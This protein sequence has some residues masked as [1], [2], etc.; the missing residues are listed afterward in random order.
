MGDYRIP[1]LNLPVAPKTTEKKQTLLGLG[2]H[3]PKRVLYGA[4]LNS[5]K[6]F[7][8]EGPLLSTANVGGFVVS[9]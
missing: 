7:P 2:V 4:A 1:P 5:Q 3:S 9:Q 6:L 8:Q